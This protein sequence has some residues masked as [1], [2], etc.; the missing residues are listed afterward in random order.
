MSREADSKAF[1]ERLDE[2]NDSDGLRRVLREAVF[3]R[4][5]FDRPEPDTGVVLRVGLDSRFGIGNHAA[6][7]SGGEGPG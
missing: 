3:R 2:V 4:G 5:T 1:A 7:R 6:I